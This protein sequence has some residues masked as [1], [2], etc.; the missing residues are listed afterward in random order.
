M[1]L[2]LIEPCI[3]TLLDLLFMSC[4]LACSSCSWWFWVCLWTPFCTT[5]RIVINNW[6]VLLKCASEGVLLEASEVVLLKWSFWSSASEVKL[7][8]TNSD[9]QI[10][11]LSERSDQH[12]E[13]TF[14]SSE[15]VHEFNVL[16][17]LISWYDFK[18]VPVLVKHLR[19]QVKYQRINQ[20]PFNP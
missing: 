9:V 1:P 7:L 5:I 8:K 17:F 19:A 13:L 12:S 3:C 18:P 14:W 16:W 10:L 4:V 11:M 6:R 20:S 2:L 15:L